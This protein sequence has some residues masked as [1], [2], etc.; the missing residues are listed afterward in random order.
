MDNADNYRGWDFWIESGTSACTSSTRWQRRRAEGRRPQTQVPANKWTHVLRHLRRLGKAA[1]VKVYING[2]PQPTER[3][4][5]Q[6]SRARSAPRCRS[7][8]ASG[9]PSRAAAGPVAPGPAHLQPGV[10]AARG[11]AR[12]P[13][14]TRLGSA[15]RQAGRRSGLPRR[16]TSCT[17]GGWRPSTRQYATL[18]GQVARL[19]ARAGRHQVPAARSPTSCRRRTDAAMALHPLSAA[20]TTSAATR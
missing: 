1:G 16:T 15:A 6:R 18:D 17:T 12:W 4:S 9:T 13:R 5:R 2:Q 19:R 14:A 7:R 20:S 3:A 8:S 10:A 11:R